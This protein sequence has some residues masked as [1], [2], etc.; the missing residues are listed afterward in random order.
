MERKIN[1]KKFDDKMNK[2]EISETTGTGSHV[3]D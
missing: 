1:Q 3:T 2:M